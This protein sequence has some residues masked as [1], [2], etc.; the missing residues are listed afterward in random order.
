[1]CNAIILTWLFE[2]RVRVLV[3]ILVNLSFKLYLVNN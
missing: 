2:E 1:M 3:E